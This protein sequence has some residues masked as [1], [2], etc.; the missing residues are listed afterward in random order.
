MAIQPDNIL[1][2]AKT[3]T[4]DDDERLINELENE[5]DDYLFDN[6]CAAEDTVAFWTDKPLGFWVKREIVLRY[7]QAGWQVIVRRNPGSTS[8]WFFKGANQGQPSILRAQ[9][10]Q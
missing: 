5:I 8:F 7:R 4:T 10:L 1:D 2:A 9:Q 6:F 3:P